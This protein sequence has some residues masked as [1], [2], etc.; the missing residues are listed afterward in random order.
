MKHE[1]ITAYRIRE[2]LNSL[3]MTQRELARW[4]RK[5]EATISRWVKGTRIPI[6]TE[7]P[8]LTTA[9]KC[10]CDYLLGLSDD[11]KKTWKEEQL[12]QLKKCEQKCEV[13]KYRQAIVDKCKDCGT[14]RE[15]YITTRNLKKIETE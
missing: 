6:A 2:R 8:E 1:N 12:E 3:R 14:N 13:C 7:L 5:T 9:L 10:T 4:T 15:I 11:P